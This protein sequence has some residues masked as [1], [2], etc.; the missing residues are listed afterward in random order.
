MALKSRDPACLR[1][2]K[3][4]LRRLLACMAPAGAH[5]AQ[6]ESHPIDLR[7]GEFIEMLPGLSM[8][9][10]MSVPCPAIDKTTLP[11]YNARCISNNI[12]RANYI[13]GKDIDYG[14]EE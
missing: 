4:R 11:N 14:S 9:I 8:N 6:V 5:A 7:Q 2:A 1:L 10:S 3:S 12:H 13:R